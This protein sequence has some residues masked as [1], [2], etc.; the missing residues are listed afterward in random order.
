MNA[1]LT[2]YVS[3]TL[4]QLTRV[5]VLDVDVGVVSLHL[6]K[7]AQPLLLAD[8]VTDKH[9]LVVQQHA[10]DGLDGSISG[11]TGLVVDETV[12]TRVAVLINGDLA[13]KD[14]TESSESVV[15]SLVRRAKNESKA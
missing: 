3:T 5:D 4:R 15:E 7:L 11:F 10:V 2:S 8:V 9:L 14:V 13:G 1:V 12:T 6:L